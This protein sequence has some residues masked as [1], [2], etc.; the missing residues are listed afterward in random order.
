MGGAAGKAGS[1][2]IPG[3]GTATS[4]VASSSSW[5]SSAMGTKL[6][7]TA[8]VGNMLGGIGG[9]FGLGSALGNIG[10]GTYGLLGAGGGA[11]IGATIGTIF[12]VSAR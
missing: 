5:L 3:A 1:V 12:P 4:S 2:S 10:G 11:A 6:F 9:G 7:G 8:T